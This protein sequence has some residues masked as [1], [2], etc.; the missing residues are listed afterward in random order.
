ME[1][2]FKKLTKKVGI[3]NQGKIPN[4]FAAFK[5]Y[6]EAMNDSELKSS[7]QEIAGLEQTAIGIKFE[8]RFNTLKALAATLDAEIIEYIDTTPTY[9][10]YY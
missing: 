8:D 9:L 7:L 4:N 10:F 6:I 1:Y 2:I 3:T 5:E